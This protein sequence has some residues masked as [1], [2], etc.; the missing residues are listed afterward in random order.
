MKIRNPKSENRKVYK[1][2]LKKGDQ[3]VVRSG[4]FKGQ[5]GE[6]ET[7]HPQD[8]K[9]TVKGINVVKKAV[10]QDKQNPRGGIIEITKPL[11]ASKVAIFEPTRKKPSKIGYKFDKDG[12]KTRV[13]KLSG[14]EIK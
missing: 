1:I 7:M 3:V 5:T 12:H 2:R 11:W 13:Y 6:I 8:N 9:V 14:K 4:K 10:K